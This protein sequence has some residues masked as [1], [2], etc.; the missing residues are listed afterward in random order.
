MDEAKGFHLIIAMAVLALL[1]IFIETILLPALPMVAEDL[2]VGA[3]DLAW[4]LTAYTPAG[5]VSVAIIGNRWKA[6]S[7]RSCS[8]LQ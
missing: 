1:T 2:Q 3:S 5:A 6:P 7:V 8:S 4:V